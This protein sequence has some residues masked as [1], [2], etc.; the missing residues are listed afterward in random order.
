MLLHFAI[1]SIEGNVQNLGKISL[2][3]QI[4]QLAHQFTPGP[5]L[6]DMEDFL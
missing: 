2:Q 3:H 4:L 6:Q 1:P 5:P